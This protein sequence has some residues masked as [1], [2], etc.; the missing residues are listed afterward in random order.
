M[1]N[2]WARVTTG[3]QCAAALRMMGGE[4]HPIHNLNASNNSTQHLQIAPVCS[5]GLLTLSSVVI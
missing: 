1:G 3:K 5:A 4:D 2:A